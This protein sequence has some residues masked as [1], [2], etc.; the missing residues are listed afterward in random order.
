MW[1]ISQEYPIEGPNMFGGHHHL[2]MMYGLCQV[3]FFLTE[4]GEGRCR[5]RQLFELI[6]NISR[7]RYIYI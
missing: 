6:H 7:E 3:F 5:E 1:K 4:R 2:L